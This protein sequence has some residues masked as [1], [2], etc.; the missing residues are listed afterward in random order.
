MATG[1][2]CPPHGLGLQEQTAFPLHVCSE[3]TNLSSQTSPIS[4]SPVRRMREALQAWHSAGVAK[5]PGVHRLFAYGFEL[6]N[7][8]YYIR[9][10]YFSLLLETG[11]RPRAGNLGGLYCVYCV[12][13][14]FLFSW[15]SLELGLIPGN[16]R[17]P[18]GGLGRNVRGYTGPSGGDPERRRVFCSAGRC[19]VFPDSEGRRCILDQVRTQALVP[20]RS[21]WEGDGLRTKRQVPSA[22]FFYASHQ[23]L[24]HWPGRAP[25]GRMPSNYRYKPP[26]DMHDGIAVGDIARSPLGVVTAN[27]IVCAILDGTYKDVHSVLLYQNGKLVLEEYFYGYSAQR[28]TKSGLQPSLLS[29][30]LQDRDRS[31]CHLRSRGTSVAGDELLELCQSRP[32]ESRDHS[33]RPPLHE[34]RAGLR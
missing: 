11:R 23:N 28:P 21:R 14:Y 17:S 15:Q 7:W 27:A 1:M 8:A 4:T 30:H 3:P 24:P 2:S 20:A 18:L 6:P 16:H 31:R 13:W 19:Q 33:W 29:A 5:Q 10:W 34:L 22:N 25:K 9:C 32:T 12:C 26:V